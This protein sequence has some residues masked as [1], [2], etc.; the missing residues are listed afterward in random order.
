VLRGSR[1]VYL[2]TLINVRFPQ[3]LGRC[4]YWSEIL[5]APVVIFFNI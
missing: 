4:I 5:V 3:K 1:Y 2:E